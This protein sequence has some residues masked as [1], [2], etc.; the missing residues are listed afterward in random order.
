MSESIFDQMTSQYHVM[1]PSERKLINYIM[2]NKQEVQYLSISSL[3]KNCGISEATITRFSHK[4][5]L[6][7]YNTLK[8][9]LAKADRATDLGDYFDSPE[10]IHASDTPDAVCKKLC[11]TYM[12]ALVDTR[13]RLNTDALD[14]AADLLSAARH[15][16]CFGQGGSMVIAMEAWAHFSTVS[17]NF[18][19]IADSHMQ[20]MTAALATPQDAILFFSYS[21]ATKELQEIISLAREREVPFI[22][23]THF[24][25]API[26]RLADVALYCGYNENPIQAGSI[27]AKMGQLLLID[28]LFYAYCSR[29]S[30]ARAAAR[31]KVVEAVG[32]RLL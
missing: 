29:N 27:A 14:K 8:I 28:C 21:A 11:D 3:A 22:L 1:T 15:V 7:G 19:H 18:I 4:L 30:D 20:L 23:V 26:A 5:G 2:D 13:D 17:Q 9:A 16:Y 6:A 24:C 12:T 31:M 25:N 10:A 32:K